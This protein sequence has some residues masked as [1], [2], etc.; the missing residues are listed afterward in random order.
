MRELIATPRASGLLGRLSRAFWLQIGMITAAAILGVFL[1]KIVIEENLVKSAILE[2]VEYF[3]KNYHGGNDFRLPD[4]KNLT[5][6]FD[7]AQLPPVI[8]QQLPTEPG[9]HD[10]S[11]LDSSLVLYLDQQRGQ[12]L[13]LVFHR[14]QVDA[15]ILYYGLFPLL[16]VLTVLYLALW[17]AYRFSRRT[18][19]P[20]TRLASRIDDIELASSEFSLELDESGLHND[21]EIAILA[22]AISDLGERLNAFISR[23]RNFT[24]NASH[25]FRS[26]LTVINVATDMMLLDDELPPR[27]HKPLLKIKRA[28]YDLENLTEVFLMLAREDAGSLTISNVDVN[29]IAHEQVE[30]A[31]FLQENNRVRVHIEESAQLAIRTSDTVVAVLLGNLIRNAVLYTERGEIR[32][33]IDA[34]GLTISD[35]GPGIDAQHLEQIFEPFERAGNEN[36]SGHGIGLTIVKRLCDRFGWQISVDSAPARGTAFRLDFAAPGN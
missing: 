23:E 20:L 15:L 36:A 22:N 28:V 7:P 31:E 5:A 13:Y 11:D 33:A 26:P 25:E 24:R 27:S 18:L 9:F 29:R 34:A 2:E 35:S 4:T 21:D 14:G 6:Y 8:R 30:R 19:S 16:V 12:D 17:F 32:V 10:Y 3:W 1:A